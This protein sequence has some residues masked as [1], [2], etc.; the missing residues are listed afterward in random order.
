VQDAFV[1]DADVFGGFGEGHDGGCLI[2]WGT[3]GKRFE[4]GLFDGMGRCEKV[5]V[6][7]IRILMLFLSRFM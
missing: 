4:V 6:R 3:V 2:V 5:Q 7:E 1:V